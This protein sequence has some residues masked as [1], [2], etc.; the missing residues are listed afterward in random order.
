M[1]TRRIW[2]TRC[3]AYRVVE[4]KPTVGPKP[5]TKRERKAGV[6]AK[7]LSVVYY[8]QR[9]SDGIWLPV[10]VGR[11]HRTQEAARRAC[12]EHARKET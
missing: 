7:G 9:Y 4:S 1:S 6:K 10:A 2:M 8:A 11:L 12:Q 3:G 5:L